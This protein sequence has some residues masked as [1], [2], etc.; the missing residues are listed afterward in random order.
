[1]L[2]CYKKQGQSEWR[3]GVRHLCAHGYFDGKPYRVMTLMKEY[4]QPDMNLREYAYD[5]AKIEVLDDMPNTSNGAGKADK[6]LYP[7]AKLL[8]DVG[9]AYEKDKKQLG[10]SPKL[11]DVDKYCIGEDKKSTINTSDPMVAISQA[12]EKF[13]KEKVSDTL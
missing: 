8:K 12:A 9:K 2:M 4:A 5:F 6:G 7:L 1:M 11:T 10:E 13:R 3:N